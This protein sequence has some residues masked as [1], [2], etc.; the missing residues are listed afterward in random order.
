MNIITKNTKDKNIKNI[1]L[2]KNEFVFVKSNK[3]KKY[4]LDFRIIKNNETILIISENSIYG[5]YENLKFTIDLINQTAYLDTV[6][7]IDKKFTGTDLVN[8]CIQIL[9]SLDIKI[10]KLEDLSRY[11]I[12]NNENSDKKE[13]KIL[14]DIPMDIL[15]LIRTERTYYMRF[16]FLPYDKKNNKINM[17]D[18]IVNLVK[19]LYDIEWIEFDNLFIEGLKLIDI[20]NKQNKLKNKFSNNLNKIN[21][22]NFQINL[23]KYDFA[24][25]NFKNNEKTTKIN[26][27]INNRNNLSSKINKK[28][29][30]KNI[31]LDKYNK[32]V[33]D[34]INRLKHKTLHNLQNNSY[35]S[36]FIKWIEYWIIMSK[37][38]IELR[39]K[40]KLLYPSPFLAIKYEFDKNQWQ[41][42]TSWLDIYSMQFTKFKNKNSYVFYNNFNKNLTKYIEIPGYNIMKNIRK[43]LNNVN[44]ICYI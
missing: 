10:I 1:I 9:K 22:S 23:E 2:N 20:A 37:S 42:F 24:N 25:F 6:N 34:Y 8:L 3:N 27:N 21:S 16:C 40:Y 44:W 17:I 7:K 39:K 31:L 29:V 15:N 43:I 12:T 36:I 19:Q 5:N 18:D 30:N 33:S 13:K 35:G 32:Y 38:Y 11:I 14:L 41:M 28:I 26:K 4:N